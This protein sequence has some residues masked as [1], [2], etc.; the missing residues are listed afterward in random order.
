MDI[1][2]ENGG[3]NQCI[4]QKIIEKHFK[5]KIYFQNHKDLYNITQ[6]QPWSN[7]ID[8]RRLRWTGHVLRMDET[9]PAA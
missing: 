7:K 8:K 1:N 4:S 3:R 5:N 6:E 9:T 2:K